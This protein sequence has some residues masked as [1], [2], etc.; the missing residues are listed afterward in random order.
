MA[1]APQTA[2]CHRNQ[3]TALVKETLGSLVSQLWSRKGYVFLFDAVGPIMI[4]PYKCNT[5]Y[6]PLFNFG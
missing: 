3:G 1:V 6:T 2:K 4:M 5:V